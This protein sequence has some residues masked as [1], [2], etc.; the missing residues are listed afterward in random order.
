MCPFPCREGGG[1][2]EVS[3]GGRPQIRKAEGGDPPL[4]D[5]VSKS[6]K[7]RGGKKIPQLAEPHEEEKKPPQL[8]EPHLHEPVS[9]SGKPREEK[10]N[11]NIQLQEGG[12]PRFSPPPGRPQWP[13]FFRVGC[14]G[15]IFTP[16]N[17][18]PRTNVSGVIATMEAL[19]RFDLPLDLILLEQVVS[20]LYSAITPE[21]VTTEH[22]PFNCTHSLINVSSSKTFGCADS[23]LTTHTVTAA[24]ADLR[25]GGL[26]CAQLVP[27]RHNLRVGKPFTEHQVLCAADP[28]EC[29]QVSME[30]AA[31]RTVHRD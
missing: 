27:S 22:T 16:G 2:F 18:R 25:R 24:G 5:P 21:Q 10:K 4:H 1:G 29:N 28:R 8:E 14:W 20:S 26:E 3:G 17:R 15:R 11:D 31:P 9:K 7:P 12:A 6:G 19:L 23:G 13:T 30:D